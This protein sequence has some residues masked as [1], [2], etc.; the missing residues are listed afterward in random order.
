MS[1]A[2][3][4]QAALPAQDAPAQAT[5]VYWLPLQSAL[6]HFDVTQRDLV[7]AVKKGKLTSRRIICGDDLAVAL[8]SRELLESYP[9]RPEP[10]SPFG[11]DS[12]GA[13]VSRET[14]RDQAAELVR[15][16]ASLDAAERV[17]R[18]LQRYA[19]RLEA[20]L[21]RAR[22][23]SLAL[24]RALGRA[25]QLAASSAAAPRRIVNVR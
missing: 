12:A 25:E 20:E 6:A 9:R 17:E 21:Q 5:M 19:D 24:A 8:C 4:H 13:L 23:E 10:I 18:A 22:Q 1:N 11:S 14:L 16:Q 7:Q 2:V 15:V 3:T